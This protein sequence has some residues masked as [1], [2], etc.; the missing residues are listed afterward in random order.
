MPGLA[1]TKMAVLLRDLQSFQ[2]C[3]GQLRQGTDGPN[4]H[5]FK[6][7]RVVNREC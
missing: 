4:M 5:H 3:C 7:V 2:K 1:S 6:A